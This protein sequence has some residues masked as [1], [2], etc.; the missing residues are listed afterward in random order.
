MPLL[1]IN[2]TFPRDAFVHVLLFWLTP[3]STCVRMTFAKAPLEACF[4][5]HY[6]IL[7]QLFLPSS[8]PYLIRLT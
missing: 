2:V 4:A 8:V 6:L 1:S 7:L 5:S 3:V